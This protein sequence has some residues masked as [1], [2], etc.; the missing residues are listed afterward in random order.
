MSFEKSGHCPPPESDNKT[1]SGNTPTIGNKS[2]IGNTPTIG[3][4]IS[5]FGNISFG[6]TEA[7]SKKPHTEKD[8]GNLKVK[9]TNENEERLKDGEIVKKIDDFKHQKLNTVIPNSELIHDGATWYF[10]SPDEVIEGARFDSFDTEIP[11]VVRKRL[12]YEIFDIERI[13]INKTVEGEDIIQEE[14]GE[15]FL[16]VLYDNKYTF[17]YRKDNG[18]ITELCEVIEI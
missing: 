3:N 13:S 4:I 14:C 8:I 6:D 9:T 16:S 5:Q 2:T 17:W 18:S 12:E 10:S 11:M 15:T 1:K 7:G